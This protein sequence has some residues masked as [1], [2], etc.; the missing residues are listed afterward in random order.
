MTGFQKATRK[1]TKLKLAITGPSGSGKT[2]SALRLAT[3][4]GGKIAFIDTENGSASL[5]SDRFN[6]DVLDLTPPFDNDKFIDAIKLATDGGYSTI[7][8]DSASHFWEG[9]LEYKSKLDAR[10][11]SNSYTN[12][13]EA[14]K[15][16]KGVLD[17]VLHSPVHV[18]CCM[19]SKMEY[20]LETN[21]KGKQ[22]PKKVGLAPIMRDGS[23]YEYTTV[24][25]I[26]M[27][28]NAQSSKDR[29]G[30]FRDNIFQVTEDTGKQFIEWLDKGD[31]PPPKPVQWTQEQIAEYKGLI[32]GQNPEW[33][34]QFQSDMKGK[35]PSVIIV[36]LKDI[37]T[38]K[39]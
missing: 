36:N 9:I 32:A 28:H 1:K 8:I 31:E 14:G 3:G 22:A 18:I 19:R 10:P 4:M 30:M 6:F 12:W 20:I 37:L 34:A 27:Q 2:Y 5:Y 39:E 25:D 38:P 17:A 26:D 33:V 21:E 29:T 24:F 13:N 16:F 7:I 15:K 23:E 11:G 35:D